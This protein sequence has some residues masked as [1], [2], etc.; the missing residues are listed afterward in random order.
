LPSTSVA[1]FSTTPLFSRAWFLRSCAAGITRRCHLAGPGLG[2][3]PLLHALILCPRTLPPL[4]L[5][6]TIRTTASPQVPACGAYL[7]TIQVNHIFAFLT[8]ASSM[9][10]TS[11][12][13]LLAPTHMSSPPLAW[14][15]HPGQI[16]PP[17]QELQS[18]ER[19]PLASAQLDASSQ[20]H[21]C[22][23]GL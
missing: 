5:L 20:P 14:S 15:P 10:A 4:L 8:A 19:S 21:L 7:D 11:A 23:R 18:P 9:V 2:S 22:S 3:H 12:S 16:H 1:R 6:I 17:C 13:V